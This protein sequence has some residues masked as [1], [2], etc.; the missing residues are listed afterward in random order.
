MR[1]QRKLYLL[2]YLENSGSLFVAPRTVLRVK[3]WGDFVVYDNGKMSFT[4]IMPTSD[5]GLPRGYKNSKAAWRQ[6]LKAE[7]QQLL[8]KREK[9]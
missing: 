7:K 8:K 9:A 6:A 5:L 2:I 1:L 4:H 3:A